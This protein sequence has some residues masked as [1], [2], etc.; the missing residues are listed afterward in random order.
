MKEGP[1][2]SINALKV[3]EKRYLLKDDKQNVIE[4]PLGLFKRVA[5]YIAQAERHFK[6]RKYSPS[7]VE[8]NFFQMMCNLEFLPNSPVLMNAAT[9]I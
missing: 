7:Q 6:S 2:L 3:L 8:E 5:K 9:A 1:K 4:T